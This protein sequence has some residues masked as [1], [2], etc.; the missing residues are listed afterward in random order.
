MPTWVPAIP[1]PHVEAITGELDARTEPAPSV[2]TTPR[3]PRVGR[4]PL[5][6]WSCAGW[7]PAGER[8]REAA[9]V[10]GGRLGRPGGPTGLSDTHSPRRL[11]DSPS[12]PA[13]SQ[14]RSLS[15]DRRRRA[16]PR[17]AHGLSCWRTSCRPRFRPGSGWS[18]GSSVGE[19]DDMGTSRAAVQEVARMRR[20]R[21]AGRVTTEL[22]GLPARWWRRCGGKY[23][24]GTAACGDREVEPGDERSHGAEV[25]RPLPPRSRGRCPAAV[26]PALWG[27]ISPGVPG[28]MVRDKPAGVQRGVAVLEASRSPFR[29]RNHDRPHASRV[30]RPLGVPG[31][32][33]G[34]PHRQLLVMM[35]RLEGAP[36][37]RPPMHVPWVY[38]ED[39]GDPPR[40][41][42]GVGR[43]HCGSQ[44][45]SSTC[46]A[47]R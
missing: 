15:P 37:G 9:G 42:P 23:A 43:K 26:L 44:T 46:R 27:R 4:P 40:A 35:F 16:G 38:V 29:L 36:T 24:P 19:R 7:R 14:P 41:R 5:A 21:R 30:C 10:A 17:A 28:R 45:S 12:P 31:P 39:V 8:H 32:A 34:V 11:S 2:G 18:S 33:D 25:D 3:P 22:P 13:C 1:G 20:R 6:P 47:R